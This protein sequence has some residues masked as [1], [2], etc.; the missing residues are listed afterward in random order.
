MPEEKKETTKSLGK[1]EN[2]GKAL[3]AYVVA[4]GKL[5]CNDDCLKEALSPKAKK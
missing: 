3:K 4:N 2:C 5:Y 1:C